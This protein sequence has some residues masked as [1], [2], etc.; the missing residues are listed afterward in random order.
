MINSRKHDFKSWLG[1]LADRYKTDKAFHGFADFYANFLPD[2]RIVDQ[3]NLLELGVQG[4]RSIR[5]WEEY[6][7]LQ[8]NM[9]VC[10]VDKTLQYV[11]F[12]F[13]P[14]WTTLIEFDL[15]VG[16][17]YEPLIEQFKFREFD[18]IIDDASHH[19]DDQQYS[20]GKL[21]P[22][23]KSGGY[24]VIEDLQ[25]SFHWQFPPGTLL[26]SD[27]I[28]KGF[29]TSPHSPDI[30]Q[31]EHWIMFQNTRNGWNNSMTCLIKKV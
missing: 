13:D 31:I 22:L 20:M 30:D 8:P 14:R 16:N 17:D 18:W 21:W 28:E 25:T 26:T 23:V 11:E 29:N 15:A 19:V 5:M 6:L 12:E 10:G 3:F 4:G 24:Y 7:A 9:W 27:W 1:E 2:K